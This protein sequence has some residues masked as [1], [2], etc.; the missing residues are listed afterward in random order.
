MK[1]IEVKVNG[2]LCDSVLIDNSHVRKEQNGTTERVNL[3]QCVDFL[4]DETTNNQSYVLGL[5][6]K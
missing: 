2:E 3:V 1:L 5:Y 4:I 6:S